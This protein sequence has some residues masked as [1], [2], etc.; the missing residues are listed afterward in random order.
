MGPSTGV[1]TP[2]PLGKYSTTRNR[3]FEQLS[4]L[5][6]ETNSPRA[7]LGRLTYGKEEDIAFAQRDKRAIFLAIVLE[8][9]QGLVCHMG[10][11]PFFIKD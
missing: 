4:L 1:V 7:C 5:R 9:M 10:V 11:Y 3:L 8:F 6:G 2:P